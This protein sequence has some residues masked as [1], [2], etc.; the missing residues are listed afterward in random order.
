MAG[1]RGGGGG[2]GGGGGRHSSTRIISL[3]EQFGP[4]VVRWAGLGGCVHGGG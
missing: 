3:S 4:E 2:G 1:G